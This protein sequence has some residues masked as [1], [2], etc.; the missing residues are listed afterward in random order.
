MP[1]RGI[2]ALSFTEGIEQKERVITARG[3]YFLVSR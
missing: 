2:V 1:C 3:F